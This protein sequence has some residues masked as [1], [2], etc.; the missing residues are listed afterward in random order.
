[1]NKL[2][3]I[4][5]SKDS[6]LITLEEQDKK[7]PTNIDKNTFEALNGKELPYFERNQLIAL[8]AKIYPSYLAKHPASDKEWE[9]D[10][11]NIVFIITPQGQASWH[12]HDSEL[13]FF[14]HLSYE[15]ENW[16]GHTN[17]RKYKRLEQIQ[18]KTCKGCRAET[19]KHNSLCDSCSRKPN[20]NDWYCKRRDD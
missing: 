13:V 14:K 9:K 20:K 15:N 2:Q 5:N 17:Y 6:D 19:D 4:K 18:S 3:K 8:L 10:W 16:D 11:R 1:M 12:I 7:M